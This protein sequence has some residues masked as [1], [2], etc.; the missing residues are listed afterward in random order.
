MSLVMDAPELMQ[1]DELRELTGKDRASLQS[2]W[3]T[4]HG[5]PH[6]LD[7]RRVLLSRS[8]VR[9]WLSGENVRVGG[10]INWGAVK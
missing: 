3:L 4:E 10:G 5:I 1:R 8:H 9:A 6:R 2:A 7:G